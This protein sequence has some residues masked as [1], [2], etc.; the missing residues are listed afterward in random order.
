MQKEAITIV[1]T[2]YFQKRNDYEKI[3]W[4]LGFIGILTVVVFNGEKVIA[5][6]MKDFL[7]KY[8][9]TGEDLDKF[10]ENELRQ[11]Q[12]RS[13]K[14]LIQRRYEINMN[15]TENQEFWTKK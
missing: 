11:N 8:A 4:I 2:K 13:S 12:Q 14:I 7:S 1:L 10:E 15:S 6:E 9:L 3:I 5:D